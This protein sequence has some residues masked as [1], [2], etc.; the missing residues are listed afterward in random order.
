MSWTGCSREVSR[1]RPAPASS[2]G[3]AGR[4]A[5]AGGGCR[6]RSTAGLRGGCRGGPRRSVGAGG[7]Q[8][9]VPWVEETAGAARRDAPAV[10]GG[11]GAT[12]AGGICDRRIRLL[13]AAL[14][15]VVQISVYGERRCAGLDLVSASGVR[16]STLCRRAGCGVVVA[17]DELLLEDTVIC[18]SDHDGAGVAVRGP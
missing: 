16:A 6:A 15:G 10:E 3:S 13:N 17:G 1:R 14:R 12:S 4:A 2:G 11:E 9:G 8:L 18:V 7:E 5:T